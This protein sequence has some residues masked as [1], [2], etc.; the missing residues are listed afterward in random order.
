M[1]NKY[2]VFKVVKTDIPRD[3]HPQ[4]FEGSL[5]YEFYEKE[6]ASGRVREFNHETGPE[7][8]RRYW[9]KFEDLVWDIKETLLLLQ[10]PPA[11]PPALPDVPYE[12][13]IY[14]AETTADLSAEHDSIRRE[15]TQ[16]GYHILPRE[17]LP[18]NVT[19]QELANSV[20]AYLQSSMMSIHL[21]GARSGFVPEGGARSIVRLQLDL[22]LERRTDRDFK[23]I[24]WVPKGLEDSAETEEAQKQF[25]N[26]LLR[27]SS[28]QQEAELLR[29]KIED[30]KTFM[31]TALKPAPEPVVQVHGSQSLASVYLICDKSDYEET[32]LLESY[33]TAQQCEVLP[34]LPDGDETLVAQYHR[35][36]LLE[37]DAVLVYYNRA[38]EGWAQM[39]RLELLK[40]SGL[41]RMKPV[42]AKAF[43]IS[44][45]QT[46]QKERFRSNEAIVIKRYGGFLSE[47]LV[48]FLAAI[49]RAQRESP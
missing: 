13:T 49:G 25:I 34:S 8:D 33:L 31:H 2:R 23:R 42:L 6:Q 20:R 40:L 43:Y 5:G 14:L 24:I 7:R 32:S 10:T 39:K 36:S 21:L 47:S 48:P 9:E 22:T 17:D 18:R 1:S 11:T 44:G 27:D 41:G 38:S 12:K 28:T 37:C 45:D 15:L 35:E 26:D 4:Q 46:P 30:L 19:A 16:H 29:D 3:R